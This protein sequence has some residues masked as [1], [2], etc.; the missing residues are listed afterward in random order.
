MHRN[1]RFVTYFLISI[2]YLELLL[3]IQAQVKLTFA[4][5]KGSD[6][7][8]TNK[9]VASD[10]ITG[11]TSHAIFPF[12]EYLGGSSSQITVGNNKDGT[13]ALF[14]LDMD[15]NLYSR[16]QLSPNTDNWSDWSDSLGG[17]NAQIAVGNN[18]DGSLALFAIDLTSKGVFYKKQ[19]APYSGNWGNWTSLDGESKQIAV[20]NDQDG[21]L[22]LFSLDMDGNLYSRYQLSPNSGNWSD[23]S[24]NLGGNN[25]QIAVGNNKD[26]RLVIFS[27][28]NTGELNSRQQLSPNTDNWSDWSDSLGG[29]NAQIAVGN[30]KDGS[31]ALFAIDLTSQEVFYKKQLAPNSGNWGNWT[32]LDGESK[33]IAVGNLKDGSLMVFSIGL[34]T[35][36]ATS[37]KDQLLPNSK[38]W[39]NDWKELDG[40]FDDKQIAL[41]N[42]KDGS[43]A[44]F[45]L[46]SDDN[47][48]YYTQLE[49][50]PPPMVR[51]E[52]L[53]VNLVAE[54][55][56]F[57]TSMAFIDTK[58]I[59]VLQKDDGKVRLVSDG[60]LQPRPLLELPVD[61]DGERGLLGVA[62]VNQTPSGGNIVG[63]LNAHMNTTTSADVFIYFTQPVS[64]GNSNETLRNRIYKYQWNGSSLIEPKLILD[65]PATS[66]IG[67]HN[68]GKL[69][70][71]TH[72]NVYAIIGDQEL[73]DATYS[74][75]V[76]QNYRNGSGPKDTG[77][78][79][80]ITPDGSPSRDNPFYNTS[81]D[82]N[83]ANYFAY[84]IRNSF[85]LALDPMTGN[86]WDT[87]NGDT[88]YD[89]INLVKPG[90]NSGWTQIMGPIDRTNKTINDLVNFKGSH[91]ADPVFSWKETLGVTAIEFL[92]SSK[93]GEK[94][95]NNI[96][97]GDISSGSLY[98]FTLN[99][100]RTGLIFDTNQTG[101]FDFVAD[102]EKEG[103]NTIFGTGFG[104]I[105]DI[106]TGPD[107]YL[108]ILSFSGRIFRITPNNA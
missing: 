15:G 21:R 60:N 97:V 24:D 14:S 87:E 43:I 19:L 37:Y 66:P 16:Q 53:K 11:V 86:L 94:Y 13:L 78:I 47:S 33:Q 29:N 17:N 28:S 9:P 41:G 8:S 26:G 81:N 91:Y 55:M 25:T 5:D 72:D 10:N 54:G 23:W 7:K 67:G 48:T 89:E 92:N 95:R 71:D 80:R 59:L 85:G 99:D 39:A 1:K 62:V 35:D 84:G 34:S 3:S 50:Q 79:L 103:N 83:M 38:N 102:N 64:E 63:S 98:F 65:L 45:F 20:G 18:K 105:T 4:L 75:T 22:R 107:G 69:V 101:L 104:G 30:N 70:V 68:G 36:N 12:H 82:V 49:G 76:L 31:L 58:N 40:A 56:P 106:K 61:N 46:S 77:V 73:S 52:H 27:L 88:T 93:L 44:M 51:D 96:F 2:L 90:F 57:P 32:S 74:K 42:N 108:Y 100:N 6:L